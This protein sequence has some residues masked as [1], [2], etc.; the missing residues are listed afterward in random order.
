[1]GD[2]KSEVKPEKDKHGSRMIIEKKMG[3]PIE[4]LLRLQI[5]M[6][7]HPN[8]DVTLMENVPEDLY[9]P[10][11]WFEAIGQMSSKSAPT[12]RFFTQNAIYCFNRW[13]RSHNI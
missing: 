6:R 11:M 9:L 13:T 2:K 12:I 8:A 1:M 10:V 7:I 4:F 5:N 3:I